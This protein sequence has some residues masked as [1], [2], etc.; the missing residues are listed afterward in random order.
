MPNMLKATFYGLALGL[1][2]FLTSGY[3]VYVILWRYAGMDSIPAG[4]TPAVVL[5]GVWA[6]G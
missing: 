3:S 6:L 2:V 5:G 1:M 4:S